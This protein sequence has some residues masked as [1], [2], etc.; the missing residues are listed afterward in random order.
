MKEMRQ[1][2]SPQKDKRNINKLFGKVINFLC[3]MSWRILESGKVVNNKG[4]DKKF[5][6]KEREKSLNNFFDLGINYSLL[7]KRSFAKQT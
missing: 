5:T 1:N 4:F 2:F 6:N 3:K 7:L